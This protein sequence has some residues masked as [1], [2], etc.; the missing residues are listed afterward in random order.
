MMDA[1]SY[2]KPHHYTADKVLRIAVKVK[3]PTHD[4]DIGLEYDFYAPSKQK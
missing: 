4:A 1:F 2:I 3:R